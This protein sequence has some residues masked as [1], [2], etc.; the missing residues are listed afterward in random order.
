MVRIWQVDTD[1]RWLICPDGRKI[2]LT[3]GNVFSLVAFLAQ[4]RSWQPVDGGWASRADVCALPEW[5][6]CSETSAGKM[7]A[8]YCREWHTR[9][10]PVPIA[11]LG[12]GSDECYRFD[13]HPELIRI[14]G[15]GSSAATAPANTSPFCHGAAFARTEKAT[16]FVRCLADFEGPVLTGSALQQH[17]A[18][19]DDLLAFREDLDVPPALRFL[20]VDRVLSVRITRDPPESL[21]ALM[22]HAKNL[23]GDGRTWMNSRLDVHRARLLRV[24]GNYD[25][26]EALAHRSVRTAES[27]ASPW[28]S[29][30]VADLWNVL[31]LAALNT[32]RCDEA[33]GYLFRCLV[34]RL[35]SQNWHLANDACVNLGS[36][37]G[38][39]LR[40]IHMGIRWMAAAKEICECF[41]VGAYS[42]MQQ[43]VLVG[44][45][46]RL[47]NDLAELE[48]DSVR[49]F[50]G[51]AGILKSGQSV[52]E[53]MESELNEGHDLSTRF[54]DRRGLLWICSARAHLLL[55]LHRDPEAFQDLL[56]IFE[57]A[58]GLNEPPR[59]YLPALWPRQWGSFQN[60]LRALD[61]SPH[62]RAAVRRCIQ[63]LEALRESGELPTAQ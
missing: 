33:V 39:G 6:D 46:S 8:R 17:R 35:V 25:G 63:E 22:R 19:E 43:S 54:G 28:E 5:K 52:A 20:T 56:Q 59:T 24:Q 62:R 26:S 42:G 48:S 38:N 3:R 16:R 37:I 1:S 32:G 41:A 44:L 31:G 15:W 27:L 53:F 29:P 2:T 4:R 10:E 9:G 50:L 11:F 47:G 40:D 45:I 36:C 51:Q 58:W 18:A 21:V 61:S 55:R 34:G 30:S 60:W 13:A 12:K 57:A 14:T 49:E 7:I 23:A